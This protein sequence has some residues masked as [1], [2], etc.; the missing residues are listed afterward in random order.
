MRIRVKICGVSSAEGIA[1]AIRYGADAI[2]FV[3]AESPRRVTPQDALHLSADM[4]PFVARVAVFRHPSQEDVQTV[5]EEFGPDV[6]QSEPDPSVLAVVPQD[7]SWLPVLHDRASLVADALAYVRRSEHRARAVLLEAPGRGGRGVAA[8][9][10]RA[11]ELATRIPIVLAG[12]LTADN[13]ADAIRLVRP[14]AVD[15]S[16]GVESSLGRKDP[17]RI[18]AF[19][20]AVRHAEEE[21]GSTSEIM[22]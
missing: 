13:V 2:G 15:V 11:A 20:R 7:V 9:W 17:G 12:G 18:A 4:P 3:F 16:S 5:L 1:A 10:P 22:S 6:V 19:L 14:Y 8:D 21:I